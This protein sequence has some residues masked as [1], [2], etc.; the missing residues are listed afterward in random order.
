MTLPSVHG[1]M[2]RA[3]DEKPTVRARKGTFTAAMGGIGLVFDGKPALPLE[4]SVRGYTG[5]RVLS[6][7]ERAAGGLSPSSMPGATG[8][9]SVL[10]NP[11]QM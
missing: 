11:W 2:V 1:D 5:N 7:P 4:P 3:P 6:P 8:A 10:G 9:V